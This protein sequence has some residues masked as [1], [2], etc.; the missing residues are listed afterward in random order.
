MHTIAI[1][2][3]IW[4]IVNR[5]IMRNSDHLAAIVTA[6]ATSL[7]DPWEELHWLLATLEDWLLIAESATVHELGD[8]LRSI[9]STARPSDMLE[10]IGRLRCHIGE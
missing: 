6:A 9:G 5:S 1:L 2:I 4:G 10:L 7:V 3:S 8:F